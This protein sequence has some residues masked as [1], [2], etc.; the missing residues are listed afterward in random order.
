[1]S[2]ETREESWIK[3]DFMDFSDNWVLELRFL[4][5]RDWRYVS[6]SFFPSPVGIIFV[7]DV[8]ESWAGKEGTGCK[9]TFIIFGL[10]GLGSF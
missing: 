4:Q 1:M 8:M 6:S 9:M 3:Q 7:V 5:K 10:T 2:M